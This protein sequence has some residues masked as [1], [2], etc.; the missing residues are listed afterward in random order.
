MEVET[1]ESSQQGI[2]E[3]LRKVDENGGSLGTPWR[4]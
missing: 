2:A 3:L 4:A 1:E